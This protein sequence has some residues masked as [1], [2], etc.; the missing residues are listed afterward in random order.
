MRK[1]LTL[2]AKPLQPLKSKRPETLHEQRLRGRALQARNTRLM[3]QSPLCVECSKAGRIRAATERDHI[4]PLVDGGPDV[5]SNLQGLCSEC[6]KAKTA[7]EAR[8]RA[9]G[10]TSAL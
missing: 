6:H 8:R 1:L 4:V 9:S 2:T 5:E 7:A 10:Q 3:W